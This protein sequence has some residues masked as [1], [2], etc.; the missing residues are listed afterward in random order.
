[1]P[2]GGGETQKAEPI[3]TVHRLKESREESRSRNLERRAG[4]GRRKNSILERRGYRARA[5]FSSKMENT[6]GGEKAIGLTL[7]ESLS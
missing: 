6:W 7:T 2:S 4:R 5:Q 3:A 1:L